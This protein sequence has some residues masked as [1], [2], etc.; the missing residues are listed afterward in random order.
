MVFDL[1]I[2]IMQTPQRRSDKAPRAKLEAQMSLAK[3]QALEKQLKTLKK[4]QKEEA[5]IVEDLSTTGDY[6]ENAGY[7]SAKHQLRRTNSRLDK[8]KD[9][10]SRAEIIE[11]SPNKNKIEIGHSVKL[12]VA[13]QEK[14]YQIL[15]SLE[16]KPEKG[17]I[18]YHS[19]L[20]SALLGKKKGDKFY[21]YVNKNRRD[22][23]IIDIF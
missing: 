2:T 14:I 8:I 21:L 5:L 10:L 20:G 23:E 19:P 7:Q 1:V 13:N 12:R 17:L 22:Y 11:V 18:S 6:S 9:L 16:V 15:G 4:K 3:Y